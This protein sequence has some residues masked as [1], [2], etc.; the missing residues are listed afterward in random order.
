MTGK[1]LIAE[2]AKRA[3][4]GL[5]PGKAQRQNQLVI[6]D[7]FTPFAELIDAAQALIYRDTSR[8]RDRL[9]VALAEVEK[10]GRQS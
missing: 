3:V 5:W 10:T 1:E 6:T 7:E 4:K 2:A 9:K 8:N